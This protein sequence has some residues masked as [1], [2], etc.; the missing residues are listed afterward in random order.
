MAD[1]KKKRGGQPGN[2]GF[3]GSLPT[4][5]RPE[6]CALLKDHLSHGYSFESFGA[7]AGVSRQCC[8]DWLDQHE[9]FRQARLEGEPQ[10][11]FYYEKLGLAL[12]LGKIDGNVTAWIF[13]SKNIAGFK[14]DRHVSVSGDPNG[15]P[16]SVRSMTRQETEERYRELMAKAIASEVK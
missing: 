11:R 4:K 13:Q 15:A 3:T 12:A 14:S 9:D 8:Y 1:V 6:F 2:K 10:C 16:I 5:Y 7:I